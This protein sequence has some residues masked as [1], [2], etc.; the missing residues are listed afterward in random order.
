MAVVAPRKR[1]L[2]VAL[3]DETYPRNSRIRQYLDESLQMDVD[4][5]PLSRTGGYARHCY[6]LFRGGL[7]R[8]QR[9]DV[10]ISAEFSLTFAWVAWVLAKRYRAVF[11]VD[12]FVGLVE[13]L[14]IDRELV[15]RRSL[16]ARVLHAFDAFAA[17]H[18]DILIT[19]T[20]VRA[21]RLS[22]RKE[23]ARTALSLPVGAPG[24]ARPRAVA[25]THT[26]DKPRTVQF[27]YYGNYVP[28]H[29]VPTLLRGI[30]AI[31]SDVQWTLTMLGRGQDLALATAL[32]EELGLANRTTFLDSVPEAE[33]ADVVHAHDVILGIFGQSDK[34]ATV[35]ANKVWQGLAS[36]KIVVTR[37]SPALKEIESIV[38]PL[39]QQV[40]GSDAE[41]I[42]SALTAIARRLESSPTA[43]AM[44][45]GV[46]AD[47]ERY[48]VEK[49]SLFGVRLS[50][51]LSR[52]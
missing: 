9:Y 5:V 4:I 35:I 12:F 45:S 49:Y 16:K 20:Q 38:G 24:W 11:V 48:V 10:V 41:S 27:L 29:G 18:A 33:L 44:G 21:D 17:R 6:E 30:A 15:Q 40:D 52:K 3:R 43:A 34:A 19:D 51:I 14:V 50:D 39:L 36:G 31:D 37:Q 7:K 1:A 13:T 32:I 47:L 23:V 26:P 8:R 28:L 46:A 42:T 22:A 2:Y 25:G